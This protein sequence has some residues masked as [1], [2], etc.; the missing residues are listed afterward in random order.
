MAEIDEANTELYINILVT[1]I[2][3]ITGTSVPNV[4]MNI[5]ET[6]AIGE[7]ST[8]IAMVDRLKHTLSGLTGQ[9]IADVNEWLIA[10]GAS[11]AVRTVEL[12]SPLLLPEDHS[13]VQRSDGGISVAVGCLRA[14]HQACDAHGYQ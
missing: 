4:I 14:S 7:M 3:D 6:P 1:R 2:A 5:D 10:D 9:S 8:T 13:P 12:P 11:Y